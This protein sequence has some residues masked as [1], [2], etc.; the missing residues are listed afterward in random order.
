M[1][2]ITIPSNTLRQAKRLLGRLRYWQKKLPVITHIRVRVD[3]TGVTLCATDLDHWLETRVADPVPCEPQEFLLPH[4]ALQAAC[5]ADR[6]SNV[7][8]TPRKR[9]RGSEVSMTLLQ[10]GIQAT[11]CYPVPD[12]GEFPSVPAVIGLETSVPVETLQ[13]LAAVAGC[14]SSDPTRYVL[15]GVLFT[16]EDGG[17]LVATDG[18]R[19]ACASAKVP[20][21]SF[22]LP[23][24]AATILSESAFLAEPAR[25]THVAGIIPDTEK[26]GDS[27]GKDEVQPGT[28]ARLAVTSGNHRLVATL[29]EGNFPGYKQVIPREPCHFAI[30]P[31]ERREGL[32]A[33]LHSQDA[34]TSVRLDWG[35]K[36]RLT[37]T[38]HNEEGIAAKLEVPM[39]VHGTPPTIAFNAG[40]LADAL[41]I[42]PTMGFT[43]ELSP[44]VCS[45]PT[46]RFCVLMPVRLA[47]GASHEIAHTRQ[48]ATSDPAHSAAA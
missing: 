48:P 33:W 35:R 12:V 27:E 40:Y 18:R 44:V 5:K 31:L 19:L 8:F 36:S 41:E 3:T 11:S 24:V 32:N 38:A 17:D 10:G 9:R 34:A 2:P 37:L 6:N 28:P 46:G 16:P 39:E 4:K 23:S 26:T 43:D 22:I 1:N 42:G 47:V 15:N 29:I 21:V 14:A 13:S 45:H 30:V 7:T 20:P 25:F